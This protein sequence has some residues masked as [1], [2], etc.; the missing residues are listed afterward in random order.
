MKGENPTGWMAYVRKYK[1]TYPDV[2]PNYKELMQK[3][4]KGEPV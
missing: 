4:I 1:A 2:E 3:Y